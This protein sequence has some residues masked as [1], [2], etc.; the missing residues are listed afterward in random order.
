[1]TSLSEN[2]RA[3]LTADAEK[4]DRS[5]DWPTSSW[6]VI[7]HEGVL[8]RSIWLRLVFHPNAA[9]RILGDRFPSQF[10]QQPVEFLLI[11]AEL[12]S[13]QDGRHRQ[14]DRTLTVDH[15]E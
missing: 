13:L 15:R 10:L 4:A 14:S 8:R 6:S 12:R 11:V 9:Q 2:V 1:M 7:H 3:H 5:T